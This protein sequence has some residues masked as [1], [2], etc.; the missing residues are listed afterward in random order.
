MKLVIF[1]LTVSSSW[2]NGHATLWRGLAR[3]L[4]RAGHEVVFFERDQSFY[5]AHRDFFSA[6]ELE[7][8]LYPEWPE[9]RA[10]AELA[11]ADAAMVT[12]FCP[13]SGPACQALFA[14][15]ARPCFYDLDTPVTLDALDRGERVPYL[16]EGDL[17]AFDLVL[18]F[19]GGRALERLAGELGARRVAPLYGSVDPELH[20]PGRARSEL[21]GDLSYLGT[22][23]P[24]RQPALEQLLLVPAARRPDR[25][26]VI[27][28]AQYPAD[29][30]F[31]PNVHF[32]SHLPPPAHPAFFASSPLT[33]N[34]TRRP[35]AAL[36]FC[37]SPR[38]FEAAACAVPVLSDR[39]A[40]LETFFEPGREVLLAGDADEALD[41]LDL[42]AAEL[43]RIG[44]RARARILDEHTAAHRAAEL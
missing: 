41:A 30:P 17:R 33:L 36:G 11:D 1:G 14:S 20:Q 23:A 19:T 5:A 43:R 18:S 25:R 40:G 35:M 21:A 7:L 28:G 39:W 8:V 10:R 29:F 37:P 32:V 44:A 6:P 2:G 24:D 12:S 31:R 16:P 42:P 9:A 26:F 3:A 15:R 38:F 13:D 34:V 27:A 4:A 22:Y